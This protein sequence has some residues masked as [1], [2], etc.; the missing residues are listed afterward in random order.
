MSLEIGYETFIF[1]VME[2]VWGHIFGERKVKWP[3]MDI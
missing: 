3:P 2:V 1:V